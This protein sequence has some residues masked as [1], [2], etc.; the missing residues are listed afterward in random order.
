MISERHTTLAIYNWLAN[1]LNFNVPS[2]R[3]TVCDQSM[4]LLSAG[5][6]S[7]TQYS[8][9]NQYIRVCAMLA[10]G[11]V[12]LDQFGYPIVLYKQMLLTL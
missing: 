10:L 5:V 4:A 11:K 9:L 8:S 3:E 2:P 6:K 1:W 12:S 7:F